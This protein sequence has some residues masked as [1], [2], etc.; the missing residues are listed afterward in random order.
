MI[1]TQSF[2]G[3][4]EPSQMF[5]PP[6]VHSLS[7]DKERPLCSW[8]GQGHWELRKGLQSQQGLLITHS[9]T[10]LK[11]VTATCQE[12]VAP[13]ATGPCCPPFTRTRIL[14]FRLGLYEH[15]PWPGP[16]RASHLVPSIRCIH[17]LL[18]AAGFQE[19]ADGIQL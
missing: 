3:N 14:P 19:D 2:R 1:G 13:P 10:C 5:L 4:S 12:K 7:R 11:N 17:S 18:V 16:S 9:T 8:D 6:K 15:R